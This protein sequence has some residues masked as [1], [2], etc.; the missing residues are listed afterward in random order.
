MIGIYIF[1]QSLWYKNIL[2]AMFEH[3]EDTEGSEFRVKGERLLDRG[4]GGQYQMCLLE[5]EVASAISQCHTSV[6]GGHFAEKITLNRIS[7]N[8]WWPRMK[9]VVAET[10]R[11]CPDCQRH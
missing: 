7:E 9:E 4:K 5:N 11:R 6:L 8:V 1:Q 10:I 3:Q 2:D